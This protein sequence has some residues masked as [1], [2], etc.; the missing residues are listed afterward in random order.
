MVIAVVLSLKIVVTCFFRN[1]HNSAGITLKHLH[2]KAYRRPPIKLGS[3]AALPYGSDDEAIVPSP[4]PKLSLLS[5]D[6]IF[7]KIAIY[8]MSHVVAWHCPERRL[9]RL[10]I[11][12]GMGYKEF[13]AVTKLLMLDAEPLELRARVVNI[14][15][16]AVPAPVRSLFRFLFRRVPRYLCEKSS[17]F[18]GLNFMTWLVGPVERFDLEISQADKSRKQTWRSGVKLMECRYLAE[19]GCKAN[20]L[21]LCK[22]PTQEFFNNHL[23]VPL[24]MKPNFTDNSCELQFG[25]LALPIDQDPAYTEKCFSDCTAAKVRV[26]STGTGKANPTC[27]EH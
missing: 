8:F 18:M 2:Q 6:S 25:V 24:Y 3:T 9:A 11:K 15:L 21:H 13:V 17:L 20:C 23:G 7:D 1:S 12:P 26:S 22:G 27:S 5:N 10:M 4:I 14:L 16:T 19:A